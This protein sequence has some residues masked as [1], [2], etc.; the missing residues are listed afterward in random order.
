[1]L[2]RLC[3]VLVGAFVL[4]GFFFKRPSMLFVVAQPHMSPLHSELCCHVPRHLGRWA[5]GDTEC[6][7]LCFKH[8]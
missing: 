5:E 8:L 1:M 6:V 3:L 2:W 4:V 7:S